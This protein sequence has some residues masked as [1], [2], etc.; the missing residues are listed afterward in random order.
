MDLSGRNLVS[1]NDLETSEIARIMDVA[2]EISGD[3]RK[4]GDL[5]SGHIMAALFFEASTRTRLSFESAMQ[6]LGGKVLGFSDASTTSSKKGESLADAIRVI[7]DY[8]DV[9]VLR[10]PR[11]GSALLASQVSTVPLINAGD[12]GHRHPT[13]TLTDMFTLKKEFGRIDGLRIAVCGDLLFGRTVHS[14]LETLSRWDNNS[15]NLISP[16]EL[17]IPDWLRDNLEKKGIDFI[18]TRDLSKGMKNADAL[19]MTRIQKERFFSEEEYLRL[20]NAYILTAKRLSTAPERMIV[21]HPLPR[22]NEV[23][24][25]VDRDPRS[26]YFVQAAGGVPVRMALVALLLGRWES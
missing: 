2:L 15:F 25:D 9:I 12:G 22:V 4:H 13:Q 10:H 16:T 3:I 11:E 18:E 19:Y 17:K 14:L 24:Y 21:M 5:L 26:R 20:K 23:H 6:R 8:S 7:D 1:L